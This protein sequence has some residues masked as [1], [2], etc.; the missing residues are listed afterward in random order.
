[1]HATKKSVTTF[2]AR[3]VGPCTR[4]DR[5]AR[6]AVQSKG[7]CVHNLFSANTCVARNHVCCKKGFLQKHHYDLLTHAGKQGILHI[8]SIVVVWVF[9][10]HRAGTIVFPRHCWPSKGGL[11]IRWLTQEALRTLEHAQGIPNSIF[12]RGPNAPFSKFPVCGVSRL[13]IEKKDNTEN[14]PACYRCDKNVQGLKSWAWLPKFCRTP[15]EPF[16]NR[17]F[18]KT[19]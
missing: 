4:A 3:H 9:L 1:M 7:S 19:M 13:A 16:F 17:V 8:Y 11:P 2:A 10:L 15:K 18:I 6:N 5:Q 14:A 12:L